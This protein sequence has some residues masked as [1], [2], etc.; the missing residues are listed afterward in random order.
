MW[1]VFE[2]IIFFYLIS[3]GAFLIEVGTQWKHFKRKWFVG[4]L[5][6]ILAL[7]WLTIFYGSF[8]EVKTLVVTEETIVLSEHPT[9][10]L[11]IAVVADFHLGPYKQERWAQ[12][13][14]D[15]LMAHEPDLILIPGDF[16]FHKATDADMLDPL[17][18]LSAPYGV[19]A[20]TGNHD[21]E[22]QASQYVI[23]T[24]MGLGITVLENERERIMIGEK[25]LVLAGISDLWY[26]GDTHRA[27]TGVTREEVSIL[28]SHNPDAVLY[29]N[30]DLA[31]LVIAGHT[32]GGQ[33]RL[34]W[35]GS[36][37]R[38]PTE[39]GNAYDKGLFEYNQ[40]Q[41]FITA[42]VG[43]TGPRARLFNPPEI[44]L[45]TISL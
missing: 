30:A 32:H 12:T 22:D 23:D 15:T 45:L 21:Y 43:E 1:W 36:L 37:V 7:G 2:I 5:A 26:E 38:V 28:L 39:L 27:M 35:I 20:V 8:I 25:E 29:S 19:Y 31:D 17:A 42:G 3:V 13:V 6:V 18:E 41:L 40:Q 16:I 44:N 10:S 9:E 33:I 11:T 24:L 14:V 4:C 34:P